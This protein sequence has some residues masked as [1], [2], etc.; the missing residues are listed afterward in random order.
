MNKKPLE[1]TFEADGEKLQPTKVE[2]RLKYARKQ[3]LLF[4]L[5]EFYKAPATQAVHWFQI[6]APGTELSFEKDKQLCDFGYKL[7][8][9][10]LKIVGDYSKARENI[11]LLSNDAVLHIPSF[12][13]EEIKR[14]PGKIAFEEF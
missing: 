6:G 7:R 9:F 11:I 14:P 10:L 8:E 5:A 2:V 12:I 1:F 4:V 3:L 13:A